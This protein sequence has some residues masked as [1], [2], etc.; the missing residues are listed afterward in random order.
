MDCIDCG[1]ERRED[2]PCYTWGVTFEDD[3]VTRKGNLCPK[4]FRRREDE[5]LANLPPEPAKAGPGWWS[6][7]NHPVLMWDGPL[8]FTDIP[9]DPREARRKLSAK[10]QEVGDQLWAAMQKLKGWN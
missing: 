10:L 3:H 4:C 9:D 6:R 1:R 8:D 7:T 5:Y 2:E